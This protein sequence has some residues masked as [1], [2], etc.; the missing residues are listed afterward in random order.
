MDWYLTKPDESCYGTYY[1]ESTPTSDSEIIEP[2][3]GTIPVR[4]SDK[5][6]IIT[7]SWI[8]YTRA[9]QFHTTMLIRHIVPIKKHSPL[10]TM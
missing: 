6:L 4:S 9:L 3:I 10:H 8:T 1:P 7:F 2:S 5:Y